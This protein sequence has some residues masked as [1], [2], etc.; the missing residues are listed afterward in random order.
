[1]DLAALTTDE[2]LQQ[3]DQWEEKGDDLCEELVARVKGHSE[4][5]LSHLS[6][7]ELEA[8]LEG[9]QQRWIDLQAVLI[10]RAQERDELLEALKQVQTILENVIS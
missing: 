4:T 10:E 1:M 3:M 9:V 7:D 2:L 6:L 5:P 8:E